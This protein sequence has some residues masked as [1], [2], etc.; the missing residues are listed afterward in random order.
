M[1]NSIYKCADL[2]PGHEKCFNKCY[3]LD[4]IDCI[5]RWQ[6][7]EKEVKIMKSQTEIDDEF[8]NKKVK[9]QDE[10]NNEL[11]PK[12]EI[13]KII[14]KKVDS[15]VKDKSFPEIDE[16]SMKAEIKNVNE[17]LDE[18]N[19]EKAE[20]ENYIT[21]RKELCDKL[22]DLKPIIGMCNSFIKYSTTEIL[23]N[24]E[25]KLDELI[26]RVNLLTETLKSIIK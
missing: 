5:C 6:P 16:M 15:V 11:C 12:I 18:H 2:C 22:K 23:N 7:P 1:R 21:Q 13:E 8:F 4:A 24:H 25:N 9:S 3:I 19:K 20:E 17:F 10:I 14:D 26:D